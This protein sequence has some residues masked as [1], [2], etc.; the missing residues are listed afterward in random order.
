MIAGE[1]NPHI[2]VHTE[3]TMKHPYCRHTHHTYPR[4]SSLS[5]KPDPY[6]IHSF[7]PF[8]DPPLSYDYI[9]WITL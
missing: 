6:V 7:Y 3:M 4:P 8:L 2:V 5:L 1:I 9:V